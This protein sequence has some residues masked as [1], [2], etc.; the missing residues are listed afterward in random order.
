MCLKC[1]CFNTNNTNN[2]YYS[3]IITLID[4]INKLTVYQIFQPTIPICLGTDLL[5][6]VEGKSGLDRGPAAAENSAS[7]LTGNSEDLGRFKLDLDN[8]GP[9]ILIL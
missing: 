5:V 4:K 8:S 1:L 9:I 2:I 7:L 6:G 3:I